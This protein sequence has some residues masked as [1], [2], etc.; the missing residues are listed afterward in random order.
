ML[1][2]LLYLISAVVIFVGHILVMIYG[3]G[4]EPNSWGWILFGN[5]VSILIAAILQVAAKS[6]D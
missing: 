6:I 2:V 5:F 1:S 4:L 3:W